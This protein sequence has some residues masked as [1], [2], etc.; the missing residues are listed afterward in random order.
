MSLVN[1][2]ER[3]KRGLKEKKD[4]RT[5]R[6]RQRQTQCVHGNTKREEKPL[7]HTPTVTKAQEDPSH[8]F[9]GIWSIG[10]QPSD[11]HLLPTSVKEAEGRRGGEEEGNLGTKKKRRKKKRGKRWEKEGTRQGEK[12]KWYDEQEE[13]QKGERRGD[14]NSE[15]DRRGQRSEQ[16]KVKRIHREIW[17]HSFKLNQ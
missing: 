17:M 10:L 7:T 3:E 4:R 15:S 5:A 9:C 11:S 2:T 12:P 13:I 16:K 1:E 6:G 14:R 8:H